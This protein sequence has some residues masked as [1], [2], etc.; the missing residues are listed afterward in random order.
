MPRP[1][2]STP[3]MLERFRETEC[4]RDT[5]EAFLEWLS[6]RGILLAV[7]T[8][9]EHLHPAHQSN[10]ELIANFLGIDLRQLERERRALLAELQQT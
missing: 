2:G 8:T 7:W 3:S 5:L 6:T 10:H 4:E 1:E 9:G